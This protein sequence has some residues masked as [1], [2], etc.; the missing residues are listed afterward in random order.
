MPVTV[1]RY[2]LTAPWTASGLAQV[3][4]NC[5]SDA[6]YIP[7]GWYSRFLSGTVENRVLQVVNNASKLRGIVYYHFQFTTTTINIRTVLQW[8]PATNVPTGIAL[9]DYTTT[10]TNDTAAGGSTTLVSTLTTNNDVVATTF[11]SQVN[12]DFSVIQIRSGSLSP[13]F[14]INNKSF[15]ALPFIDHNAVAF[16]GAIT[17]S[18]NASNN[19][20]SLSTIGVAY[21]TRCTFQFA[22]ALR[23]LALGNTPWNNQPVHITYAVPGNVSN[24]NGNLTASSTAVWLPTALTN[25]AS[26]I[27]VDYESIYRAPVLSYTLPPAPSDFAIIPIYATSNLRAGDAVVVSSG[28]EEY[29]ILVAA[30]GTGSQAVF[31]AR[32]V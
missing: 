28:V 21:P 31:G 3:V 13:N 9:Q 20:A 30:P 22:T 2:S 11:R 12:P 24:S 8:N 25:T 32:T 5:F 23:N 26:G 29:E 7:S 10:T 16:N 4:E 1:S 6:G 27:T 19:Y 15:N 14:I 17:V 18:D